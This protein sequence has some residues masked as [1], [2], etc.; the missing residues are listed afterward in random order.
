MGQ[1]GQYHT[2]ELNSL[3]SL[4]HRFLYVYDSREIYN[5]GRVA[6]RAA[7]SAFCSGIILSGSSVW[8]KVEE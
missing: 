4:S 3:F 1:A 2:T 7:L 8:N 5:I 6:R